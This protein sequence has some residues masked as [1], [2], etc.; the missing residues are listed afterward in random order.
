[1][2]EQQTADAI[3]DKFYDI[4]CN[5]LDAKECCIVHLNVIIDELKTL[6]QPAYARACFYQYVKI[7]IEKK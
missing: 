1:M 4:T 5:T 7:L 6:E 3:F 2:N